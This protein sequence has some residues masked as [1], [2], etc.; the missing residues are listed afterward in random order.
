M[1]K[2]ILSV[3]NKTGIVEFAKALTQ[4]NYE[5]YSTGGTKRILDEA[6]VSVRSVSDLTHFPQIM[7]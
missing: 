7:D 3:S 6:N 1:K 4:L 5:L 2:A